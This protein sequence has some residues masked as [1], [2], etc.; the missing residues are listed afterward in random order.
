MA[1]SDHQVWSIVGLL[2][3][4]G[5]CLPRCRH[6]RKP[7]PCCHLGPFRTDTDKLGGERRRISLLAR[8]IPLT[9]L[10]SLLS[11]QRDQPNLGRDGQGADAL[12]HRSSYKIQLLRSLRWWITSL[13]LPIPV[14]DPASECG[15]DCQVPIE[16]RTS[17]L[18]CRPGSRSEHEMGRSQL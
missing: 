12:D 11:S 8:P 2:H 1:R 6:D 13:V 10:P 15:D 16:R 17:S 14:R 7:Y 5:Q 3:S 4:Q 9:I 18:F